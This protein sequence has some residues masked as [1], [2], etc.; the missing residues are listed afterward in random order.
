MRF[1]RQPE[2]KSC[3]GLT[4]FKIGAQVFNVEKYIDRKKVIKKS[5]HYNGLSTK[6]NK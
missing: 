3:V 4:N 5:V 2:T 6:A 1:D